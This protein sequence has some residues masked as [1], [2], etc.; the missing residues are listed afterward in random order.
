MVVVFLD[1]VQTSVWLDK[2]VYEYFKSNNVNVTNL[3]NE[4][5][6][7]M[8]RNEDPEQ[9][10]REREDHLRRVSEIE[11]FLSE[12]EDRGR[13]ESVA[14]NIREDSRQQILDAWDRGNRWDIISDDLNLSWLCGPRMVERVKRA[15][16][17]SP[18]ECLDWLK[19]N[20]GK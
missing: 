18:F 17:K 8:M 13:D 12:L 3:L 9:L 5:G 11:R 19:S 7:L 6:Y 14:V 2:S 1:R 16:F 4:S 10:R 20:G 15:G